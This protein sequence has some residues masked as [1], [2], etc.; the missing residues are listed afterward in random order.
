MHCVS[1]VGFWISLLSGK[2]KGKIRTAI[3]S[4]SVAIP[5][6]SFM[7]QLKSKAH[8]S[9]F[10]DSMGVKTVSAYTDNEK[11]SNAMNC[12]AR[13]IANAST[14]KNEHCSS[15][16]CHRYVSLLLPMYTCKNFK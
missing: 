6:G 16:V 11:K 15:D 13:K 10:L 2:V 8:L 12:F 1:A 4:Q 14:S 9:Q 5:E 7:N 3:I